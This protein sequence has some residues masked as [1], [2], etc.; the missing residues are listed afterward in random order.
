[1][2]VVFYPSYAYGI[3]ANLVTNTGYIFVYP[4]Y[5]VGP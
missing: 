1:M 2:C 5:Y 3:V 4:R